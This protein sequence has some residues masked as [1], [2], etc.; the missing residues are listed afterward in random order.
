LSGQVTFQ[1]NIELEQGTFAKKYNTADLAAGI[2]IVE[3][4]SEKGVLTQ[5][6]IVKSDE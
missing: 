6:M 1:E 5:Q 2:Y 3:L 4:S